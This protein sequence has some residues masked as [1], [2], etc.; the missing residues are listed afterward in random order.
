MKEYRED[1]ELGNEILYSILRDEMYYNAFTTNTYGG[2]VERALSASTVKGASSS[3]HCSAHRHC[4][5]LIA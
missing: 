3:S 5:V 1:S 2:T 4:H